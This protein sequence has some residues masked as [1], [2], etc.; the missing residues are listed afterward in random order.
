MVSK[1]FA[2]IFLSIYVVYAV[3]CPRGTF[4]N[5]TSNIC[6]SCDF[7]SYTHQLGSTSCL[8][9]PPNHSTRKIHSKN[10]SECRS[11]FVYKLP[12]KS[13]R[14]FLEMCPPGTH[15]RKKRVKTSKRRN[16]PI[17]E[18]PTLSPHC[19]SCPVGTYQPEYGQLK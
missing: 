7:G 13:L 16:L 9:C 11:E 10:A 5:S 4:H 1:I 15:A 18:R 19:K 6:A 17:V 2:Y 14:G 12:I 8:Q 3:Q